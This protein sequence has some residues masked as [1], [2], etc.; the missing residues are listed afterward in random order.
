MQKGRGHESFSR[1]LS[2]GAVSCFLVSSFL[3][4]IHIQSDQAAAIS[5]PWADDMEIGPGT[6]S[7]YSNGMGTEW[8]WGTPQNV[9]PNSTHSGSNAW[10][11]NIDSN[12]TQESLAHLES[13]H[14]DLA[15]STNT[16]LGFW[17][18]MVTNNFS[19]HKWDGGIIDVSKDGG[20][21]WIQ[22]D[23][24]A[25]PNP[26]P[27]YDTTLSDARGNPLGGKK[28]YCYDRLNWTEI[29]VDLSE[30]DGSSSLKFRF[31]FGSDII[32]DFPGW[33]IDDVVLSG[34]GILVEP[35]YS[36][37]NLAGT[38]E[39]F[40]LTVRNLQSTSE[41]IDLA[42]SDDRGW[43][44]GLFQSDGVTPIVDSGGLPGIPDS[45]VLNPGSSFDFVA[46]VTIP[47]GTPYDT[48]DV[49][50]VVGIPFFASGPSDIA[51]IRVSTPIPDVSLTDFVIPVGQVAG[52][53]ANV[54]AYV[55]N[56]GQFPRSF[57]VRL[58]IY[59]PGPVSYNP[60]KNVVDL[61]VDETDSIVW[62]FT[63]TVPGYYTLTA[64]TMLASDTVPENNVSVKRMGVFSPLFEDDME[65]G[66]P[67]SSGQWNPETQPQNAWELGTPTTIG[68]SVCHSLTE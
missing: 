4:M 17:Y 25:V 38:S 19:S 54:T 11:T 36:T 52:E 56:L 34:E 42:F 64:M 6:W 23:D 5:P 16:R 58:D 20:S 7:N 1:I 12:Y 63:P 51:Y 30:Y 32:A 50:R 39:Q 22:I 10:G 43:P 26:D 14:F 37:I 61:D 44:V 35:D 2:V 67:A 24:A 3:V 59:G 15:L 47:A 62:T 40:N 46:E 68:P 41:I 49:V 29:S 60:V 33:Y 9:G 53:Q 18:Y 48:E 65:L 8:Q 57:D 21:S 31:T 66:G 13:P 28:A 45:G 55:T 27:Y